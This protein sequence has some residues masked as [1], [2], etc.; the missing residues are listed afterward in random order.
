MSVGFRI[1]TIR[2]G[3]S[4]KSK[5]TSWKRG[6]IVRSALFPG[7]LPC[8]PKGVSVISVVEQ[9]SRHLIFFYH[10]IHGNR[11]HRTR[12]VVKGVVPDTSTTLLSR[13]GGLVAQERDPPVRQVEG[14]CYRMGDG[15]GARCTRAALGA[16]RPTAGG[17][18]SCATGRAS[19]R[20][21]GA[22]G[23]TRTRRDAVSRSPVLAHRFNTH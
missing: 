1:G 5:G 7:L 12:K 15:S 10:G 22:R 8:R 9:G 13:Y 21:H 19:G 11:L 4:T 18:R 3:V 23:G 16:W 6:R 17:A 20:L 14:P 2:R